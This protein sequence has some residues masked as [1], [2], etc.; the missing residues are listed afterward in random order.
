MTDGELIA[1]AIA[2]VAAGAGATVRWAVNRVTKAIEA[3]TK[4]FTEAAVNSAVLAETNRALT[5]DVRSIKEW[6][7]SHTGVTEMPPGIREKAATPRARTNPEGVA[8][9]A[10]AG[11]AYGPRRGGRDG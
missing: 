1:S 8:I 3:N 11:G 10:V 7:D 5:A 6:C 4:A 9:A 2:G